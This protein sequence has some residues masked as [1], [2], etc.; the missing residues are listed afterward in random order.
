MTPRHKECLDF[1][2]TFWEEKG[3]APSYDEIRVALGAKSKASVSGLLSKL[4]GRGYI[5][6]IPN[7][8][9]SVRVAYPEEIPPSSG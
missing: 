6:R 9:R 2:K 5:K 8:A 4:E 3:Y 7:L 1:I